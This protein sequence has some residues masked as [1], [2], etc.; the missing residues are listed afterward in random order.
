VL[1]LILVAAAAGCTLDI[2]RRDK[3]MRARQPHPFVAREAA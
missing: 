2:R 3:K 1:V